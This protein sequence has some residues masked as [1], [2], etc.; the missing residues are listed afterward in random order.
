MSK[1]L[2]LSR[3]A[4]IAQI[5]NLSVYAHGISPMNENS[6]KKMRSLATDALQAYLDIKQI[7]SIDT[8]TEKFEFMELVLKKVDISN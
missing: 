6:I 5:R 2:N 1:K 3:V 8:H 4:N 7:A